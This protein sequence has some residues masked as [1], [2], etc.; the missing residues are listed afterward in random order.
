MLLSTAVHPFNLLRMHMGAS[1]FFFWAPRLLRR[2]PMRHIF[3]FLAA[4]TCEAPPPRLRFQ[5]LNVPPPNKNVIVLAQTPQKKS[6]QLIKPKET[7]KNQANPTDLNGF[8]PPSSRLWWRSSGW[9]SYDRRREAVEA[10]VHVFTFKRQI[11]W[12]K[13][14]FISGLAIGLQTCYAQATKLDFLETYLFVC[15]G[16]PY[17]A[18][19]PRG[20]R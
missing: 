7:L 9:S 6:N 19:W 8:T 4:F 15:Q 5:S 17:W 16:K 18:L 11:K 10:A 14:V 13:M 12:M 3:A 1:E 2:E 20:I